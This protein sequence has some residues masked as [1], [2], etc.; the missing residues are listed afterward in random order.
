[1]LF[2]TPFKN[3]PVWYLHQAT[4]D[5]GKLFQF[6]QLFTIDVVQPAVTETGKEI[7]RSRILL[8]KLTGF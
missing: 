7:L 5:L 4:A 1:V 8:E 3:I 2:I 6:N